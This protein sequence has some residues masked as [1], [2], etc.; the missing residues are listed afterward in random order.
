MQ[1]KRLTYCLLLCSLF[2]AV[3]ACDDDDE[4]LYAGMGTIGKNAD[5]YAITFD[6][7]RAYAL[8]DSA[9]L[10]YKEANRVGQRVIVTFAY[11]DGE[12]TGS[13]IALRSLYKVLTKPLFLAPTPEQSD[14]IGND[15]ALLE[16]VWL[17]GGCLNVDFCIASGRQAS[18][19]HLVTM[20]APAGEELDGRGYLNLEFRHHLNGNVPLLLVHGYVS[21]R[22]TERQLQAKGYRITCKDLNN[23]EQT[24][25]VSGAR[26]GEAGR[27]RAETA[28]AFPELQ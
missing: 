14:S 28:V 22:L 21:F 8:A 7:G 10:L 26:Q 6:N 4:V 12:R 18:R 1:M 5:R 20:V 25:V 24:V 15:G 27:R 2:L 9:L 19:P 17:A 16:D 11:L 3:A 13:S 23:R